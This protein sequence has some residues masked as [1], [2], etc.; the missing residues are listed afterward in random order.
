M[1]SLS[2]SGDSEPI[3]EGANIKP[4]H[5]ND[6]RGKA[7]CD[8]ECHKRRTR[9]SNPQPLAGYLSSSEAAHQFAYPPKRSISLRTDPF[10]SRHIEAV[11]KFATGKRC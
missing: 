4:C 1:L 10:Y 6:C 3:D 8:T 7:K 11:G 2:D 5:D 9:D